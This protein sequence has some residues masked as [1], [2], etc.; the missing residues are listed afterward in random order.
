MWDMFPCLGISE[1][2]GSRTDTGQLG[3]N[4]GPLC[5]FWWSQAQS[6]HLKCCSRLGI[7]SASAG[8]SWRTA[9]FERF[10][11]LVMLSTETFHAWDLGSFHCLGEVATVACPGPPTMGFAFPPGFTDLQCCP[12]H[13][14]NIHMVMLWCR[15]FQMN[16]WR[17]TCDI[18][19]IPSNFCFGCLGS[20]EDSDAIYL[21]T[22]YY[23]DNISL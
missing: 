17:F 22:R 23:I 1:T 19:E 5:P 2:S 16:G 14:R 12:L 7:W 11:Q 20:E 9:R 3:K 21:Q 13:H 8:I 18:C 4:Q 10:A 6:G 15:C